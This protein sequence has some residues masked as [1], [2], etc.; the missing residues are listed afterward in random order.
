MVRKQL[1]VTL[2]GAIVWMVIL[3]L[4]GLF[5]AKLMPSYME[6][7]AVK[8]ILAAMEESG[9]TKGTVRDIRNAFDR[10]NTIE[11]VKAIRGDDLEITKEAGEAVVTA[12]WATKIPV[13]GNFSACLD[14]TVTTAK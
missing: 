13:A 3:A 4:G 2:S 7:F 8:K 1:G 10:R 14:F 9:E 12:I 6:Y 5:A 11:D